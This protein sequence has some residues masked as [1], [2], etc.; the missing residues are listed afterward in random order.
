MAAYIQKKPQPF[1]RPAGRA[2]EVEFVFPATI[3]LDPTAVIEFCIF[4]KG[5]MAIFSPKKTSGQGITILGQVD[6]EGK[7]GFYDWE[8]RVTQP[9]MDLDLSGDF[10]LKETRL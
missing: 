8:C 10:E 3:P 5:G 7:K 6:T 9:G 1:T 4:E 2:T